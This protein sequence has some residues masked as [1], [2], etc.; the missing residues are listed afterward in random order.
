MPPGPLEGQT[1]FPRRYAARKTFFR[2]GTAPQ[3]EKPSYDPLF[4][5]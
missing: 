1:N 4:Q 3:A 5:K 2:S